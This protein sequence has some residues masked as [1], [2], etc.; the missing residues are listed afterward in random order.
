MADGKFA[1]CGVV[2]RA[3]GW[4]PARI[5]VALL[6]LLGMM[7]AVMVRVNL[8]VAIVAMVRHNPNTTIHVQAQCSSSA[9][10]SSNISS[11]SQEY[12]EPSF[13][14]T[15][16]TKLGELAPEEEDGSELM[17]TESPVLLV[18]SVMTGGELDWDEVTQGFV[19]GAFFYGY[20][21]TQ[22]L[23]GRLA[24]LYG[25]RIV[26]GLSI[27]A[28]GV[29]AILTPL[30]ARTHYGLV[31][32]LRVVQGLFQ[33][34][35]IP[36]LFPLMVRWMPPTERSR[37][38]AYVCF[39]NNL[40]ITFTMPLCGLVIESFGWDAA[41]Y[42]TGALS[43]V[44]CL[45]WFAFM[46]E[47]PGKHPR[48]CPK[49]LDYIQEKVKTPEGLDTPPSSI[50]WKEMVTSLP[51]WAI[52]VCEVGNSFGFSVYFSYIPTYMQNILGFSISENG[53]LSALP[54]LCRYLGAVVS[55]TAADMVLDRE[56]LSVITIRRIFSAVAMFGPALNLLAVAYSGCDPTVAVFLLCL[57]FL[58]NGFITTGLFAN[59]TDITTN[60]VG[61]VCGIGNTCA[62]MASVI[63]PII[64]GALT[65][66]QQT[67]G[68]WQK[69]FWMCVPIYIV[70]EVFFLIFAS[71]S[72]QK[73]NY[74]DTDKKR[75]SPEAEAFLDDALTFIP[76]EKSSEA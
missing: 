70:T 36:C 1:S 19:L 72:I 16:V 48:I 57:G 25:T 12:E 21:V 6:A 37:F 68:Q 17:T 38:I 11:V 29:S 32:A 47:T 59:K 49:E 10:S 56:L 3:F 52:I 75:G 14:Y 43:L 15:N 71:G 46:Y 55:A 8:S 60:F 54:F 45:T 67:M 24:E 53:V 50:P 18:D 42:V 63:V 33:G 20:C 73:W 74:E 27:L 40:S 13:P 41:F 22:I 65:L 2:S 66:N 62:N 35:T 31:I 51:L 58:L 26:F 39:C 7:N 5:S 4:I 76:K 23:G 30:A 44:S 28:G 34:S 69:V 61:T 64:V 9:S